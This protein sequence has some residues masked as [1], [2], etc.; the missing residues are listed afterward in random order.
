M[1]RLDFERLILLS[2]QEDLLPFRFFMMSSL[3][4]LSLQKNLMSRQQLGV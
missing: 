4:Y 2:L 1:E 3:Y